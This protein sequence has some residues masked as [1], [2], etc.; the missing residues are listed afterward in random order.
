[1]DFKVRA[2]D[3]IAIYV[4]EMKKKENSQVQMQSF[5]LIKGLLK[6]LQVAHQDKHTILFDRIKTILATMAKSQAGQKGASKDK[7]DGNMEEGKAE[8]DEENSGAKESEILLTEMMGLL[9]RPCKDEKLLKT[10]VDCFIVLTKHLYESSLDDQDGPLFKFL[11]F[12]FKEL[13]KKLLQSRNSKSA[14]LNAQLFKQ[15]FEA[16]PTLGW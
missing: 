4:K 1:M 7:S 8:E 15:V 11:V 3:F 2:L 5:D 9:L 10:Y 16:C 12:T 14:S 6:T 13:L